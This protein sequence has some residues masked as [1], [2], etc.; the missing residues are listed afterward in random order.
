[1]DP[2]RDFLIVVGIVFG[3]LFLFIVLAFATGSHKFHVTC[4]N[5]GEEVVNHLYTGLHPP[6]LMNQS[7]GKQSSTLGFYR[8]KEDNVI[9]IVT[10]DECEIVEIE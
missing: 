6:T 5:D 9:H 2:I 3:L 10:V 7:C 8:Y 4:W 1:M